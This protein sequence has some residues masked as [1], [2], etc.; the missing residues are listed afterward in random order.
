MDRARGHGGHRPLTSGSRGSHV[1][2]RVCAAALGVVAL[3]VL[4]AVSAGARR[5]ILAD[6]D[7]QAAATTAGYLGI[8]ASAS[9]HDRTPPAVRLLSAAGSLAGSSFWQ[10]DLQVWL[11]GT[12]LLAGDTAGTGAAIA[13]FSVGNSPDS[14]SVAIWNAVQV[15]GAAPLVA[16]GGGFAVAALLVI[17]IAGEVMTSRKTR[18][19]V[20]ALGLL[21]V[22]GGVFGQARAVFSTWQ[23]VHESGLL[24]ARRLLEI[25]AAGRKLTTAD[26]DAIGVGL[27]VLP[28]RVDLAIRDTAMMHDTLG[29]HLVAVAGGGQAWILSPV[30]GVQRYAGTWRALLIF[31]LLAVAG[32]FTAAALPP[33]G[34]YLSAPRSP[35]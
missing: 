11:A 10:G 20:V 22:I 2:L 32:A 27:Q 9:R 19:L 35:A 33:G 26:A 21:V 7:A 16:V 8:V 13:R 17:A 30:D 29:V 12:P 4:W 34:R 1:R 3:G 25:T 14:A 28:S 5:R 6:G 23:A 15:A 18:A 24:R 31:G